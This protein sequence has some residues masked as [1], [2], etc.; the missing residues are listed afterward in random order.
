[1]IEDVGPLVWVLV[2]RVTVETFRLMS[3]LD[4]LHIKI[5]SISMDWPF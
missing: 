4:W 3:E 5:L 1:M 2:V